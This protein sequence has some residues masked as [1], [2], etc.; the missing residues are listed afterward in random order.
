MKSLVWHRRFRFGMRTTK[1]AISVM[2]ALAVA[3]A[4]G[5][6]YPGFM[7]IGALGSMERSI[8]DS[9]RSARNLIIGN[10][11]G[12]LLATGVV[13]LFNN[14]LLPI[15][16]IPLITA[17]GIIIMLILCNQFKIQSAANL[18]C[19]VFVCLMVDIT[20]GASLT[21]G[22]VR[23]FDT[24]IGVLIALAVNIVVRPYNHKP[25]IYSMIHATEESM[26]PLLGERVLRCRIPDTTSLNKTMDHLHHE[27]DTISEE[28]FNSTLTQKDIAHI[29]GC[30]QLLT[31]MQEAL[32]AICSLDARPMPND[33]NL[34]RLYNL[35]LNRT[36]Q[37]N[38]LDGKCTFEDRTV[39]NYYLK[40]FLDAHDYLC[41]LLE[42]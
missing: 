1:T 33:N 30:E 41:E 16:V 21:Y 37:D 32:I 42:L 26:L 39:L 10:L 11:V 13:L 17:V 2:I 8:V 9:I 31:K 14:N 5:S 38:F 35:G 25:R 19:V 23:F 40:Q 24:I 6:A 20:S 27:V 12:A 4:I 22:F 7:A 34:D 28:K 29:K 36:E 3:Y 18:S 15:S